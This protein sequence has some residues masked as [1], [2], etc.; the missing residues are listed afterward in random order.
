MLL[1]QFPRL[2]C[3]KLANFQV[4]HRLGLWYSL[5]LYKIYKYSLGIKV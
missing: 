2:R 3:L 4:L 1:F 5:R